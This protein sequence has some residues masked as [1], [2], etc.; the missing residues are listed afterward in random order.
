PYQQSHGSGSTRATPRQTGGLQGAVHTEGSV[1]SCT[2]TETRRFSPP[3][4]P[5]RRSP[6]TALFAQ[7]LR[8][9]S[10]M[11]S[12]TRLA[13]S[14]SVMAAAGTVLVGRGGGRAQ[15]SRKVQRLTHCQIG[16]Q[17]VVLMHEPHQRAHYIGVANGLRLRA[18]AH[19]RMVQ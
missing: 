9:S 2:A 1:S 4:M 11:I 10:A 13:M 3:L 14:S 15:T 16:Q 17:K 19:V 12:S 8:P 5:R 18:F 6:P 7:S